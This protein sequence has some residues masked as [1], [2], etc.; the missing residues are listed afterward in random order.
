LILSKQDSSFE[1]L[2]KGDEGDAWRFALEIRKKEKAVFAELVDLFEKWVDTHVFENK[3]WDDSAS[4]MWKRNVCMPLRKT[5]VE[6]PQWV[7][8]EFNEYLPAKLP[9]KIKII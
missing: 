3:C 6:I 9:Y 5:V 4:N 7:K 1:S 8:S 2:L